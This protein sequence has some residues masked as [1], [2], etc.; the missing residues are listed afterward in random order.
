MNYFV[1]NSTGK[2]SRENFRLQRGTLI[3]SP[4]DTEMLL[5]EIPMHI[6][7]ITVQ[8]NLDKNGL[9]FFGV[10]ES[11]NLLKYYRCVTFSPSLIF[12]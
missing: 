5:A 7:I 3:L 9:S 4:E 12:R 11:F 10:C 8:K 2:I 1:V 6:K